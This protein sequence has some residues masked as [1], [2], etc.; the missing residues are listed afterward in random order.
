MKNIL[1]LHI[2]WEIEGEKVICHIKPLFL[3]YDFSVDNE[4]QSVWNLTLLWVQVQSNVLAHLICYLPES[5]S[6]SLFLS[7][8]SRE[9]NGF[10][11]F[12]TSD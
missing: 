11:Y 5:K 6:Q 12:I 4:M 8:R 3:Q 1:T 9:P 7:L 10:I 2:R